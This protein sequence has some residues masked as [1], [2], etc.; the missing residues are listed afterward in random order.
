MPQPPPTRE[1]RSRSAAL[2]PGRV[3]IS[4]Q[5]HGFVARPQDGL[6]PDRD[7]PPSRIS[8]LIQA[9]SVTSRSPTG[10]ASAAAPGATMKRCRPSGSCWNRMPRLH[11]SGS[12]VR[13]G[14]FSRRS[15]HGTVPPCTMTENATTTKMIS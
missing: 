7:Q 9:S 15:S 11:G 5:H 12:M 6:G 10:V 13:S 3:G 2:R 1:Q 8:R 14:I 4:G